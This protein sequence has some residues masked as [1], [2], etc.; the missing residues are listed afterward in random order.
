MCG[1]FSLSMDADELA[2]LFGVARWVDVGPRW[3]IAPMQEAATLVNGIR[4]E[5]ACASLRWGLVP[6][7][8]REE[9]I[10]NRMI[11]ARSE[12]AHEK[13]AFREALEFRRCAIPADGFYEW[14]ARDGA[15]LPYRIV[16]VPGIMAFAGLWEEWKREGGS[17][18]RTFTILTTSSNARLRRYHE[19]MPVMLRV[20]AVER[21]LDAALTGRE[22]MAFAL[23]PGAME[24][25]DVFRVSTRVNSPANEGAEIIEPVE[26]DAR[27]EGVQGELF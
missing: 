3:N 23:G 22:A 18:L 2:R 27:D 1:R 9:S 5:V 26:D 15:K 10:G 6:G 11:N 12:T 24:E 4:E 21:W 17:I 19:R 14:Q 25:V 7:W 13:P 8:A 20:D 16:P